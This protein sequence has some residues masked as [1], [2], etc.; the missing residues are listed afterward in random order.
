MPSG[1]GL[2]V[3]Q[4]RGHAVVAGRA[5][6]VQPLDRRVGRL[7]VR[8]GG[9]E[10]LI[11]PARLHAARAAMG[12]ARGSR[13][14]SV[15]RLG[16]GWCGHRQSVSAA[17]V[18]RRNAS[19]HRLARV[20]TRRY[21]H[22]GWGF[23]DQQPSPAGAAR[24]G[25]DRGRA[26]RAWPLE[27]ARGSRWRSTRSAARPRVR[28]PADARAR[29]ARATITRARRTRCGKSY[30][31]RRQRLSR[32]LRPSARLRRAPARRVSDVERLLE[33][34]CGRARRR[35][36]VRRR[37]LGR[38]WRHA[39]T[40]RPR[41]TARSRST[42]VPSIACSRSMRCRAR[43]ASRR[44]AAGPVLEAQLG[45]HG[46]TLRHFPQSFEYSTLGG[47]IATRA[48]GHF[49]TVWTHIED[50]VESARAITPAGVWESRR[51]PGSGRGRQPRPDARGLG[52]SA[53]SDHRGVGARAAASR[54]PALGGRALSRTSPR[55]PS[56]CGRSASPG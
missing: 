28:P 40:C 29:S 39:R 30:I 20:K 4:P 43:R 8:G 49:A 44:G 38:R 23:E 2:E 32:A 33:W 46:L 25:S 15:G 50:F 9:L 27:R 10:R 56:A 6:I 45:E 3:D 36:P 54:A 22:W 47:W 41:T 51:L 18:R 24:D 48:A 14:G 31:G 52:G 5:A 17:L 11:A 7:G 34:C 21:K 12:R 19:E 53:R 55:A 37:H 1:V 16:S 42:C 26:P 13:A 35:D